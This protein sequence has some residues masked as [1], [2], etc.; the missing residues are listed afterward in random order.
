MVQCSLDYPVLDY[1]VLDYPVVLWDFRKKN[2]LLF[3]SGEGKFGLQYV[4][5]PGLLREV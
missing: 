4:V 2:V 3:L 1:P 5:P